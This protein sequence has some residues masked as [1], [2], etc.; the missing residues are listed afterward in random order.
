[1]NHP[2]ARAV[3]L[4]ERHPLRFVLAAFALAVLGADVGAVPE[5]A[6]PAPEFRPALPGYQL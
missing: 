5:S 3:R 4:T 6:S 2:P 1:M